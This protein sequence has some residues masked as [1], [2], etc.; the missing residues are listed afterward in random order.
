MIFG[1]EA[2]AREWSADAKPRWDGKV[3]EV[4]YC[5]TQNIWLL[6]QEPR[7][8]GKCTNKYVITSHTDQNYFLL[9]QDCKQNYFY[10]VGIYL[11]S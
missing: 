5:K 8:W 9:L 7:E 6:L 1:W 3:L 11:L 4:I 10:S 2:R